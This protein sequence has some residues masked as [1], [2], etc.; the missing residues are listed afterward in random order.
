MAEEPYQVLVTGFV[1]KILDTAKY[2]AKY[3][4]TVE[5]QAFV[6]NRSA[7]DIAADVHKDMSAAGALHH[8]VAVENVYVSSEQG[9]KNAKVWAAATTLKEAKQ[10]LGKV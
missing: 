1:K 2:A 3:R 8:D 4:Q 5:H 9:D 10:K 7:S 6:Q